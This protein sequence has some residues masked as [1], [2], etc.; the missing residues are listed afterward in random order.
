MCVIMNTSTRL[1]FEQLPSFESSPLFSALEA[2]T[3]AALRLLPNVY[4]RAVA[5]LRFRQNIGSSAEHMRVSEDDVAIMQVAYL[6]AALM[7]YVGM[8]EVLPLDLEARGIGESVLTIRETR[9]ALLVILRE[10]RHLQLHLVNTSFGSSRKAAILR[11]MGKEH[12]TEVT[13]LTVPRDDLLKLRSLRNA[14]RYDPRDLE[15]AIEWFEAAQANWGVG[16]VVQA[17][18]QRYAEALVSHYRL[19]AP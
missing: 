14:S 11:G 7:D 10:M 15:R 8:E 18:I 6:R 4:A 19:A 12:P 13:V 3:E 1:L 5:A 17:G 9:D 2:D 16:D